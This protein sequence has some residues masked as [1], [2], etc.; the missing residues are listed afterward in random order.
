M[1]FCITSIPILFATVL[2]LG[3]LDT[4]MASASPDNF[5]LNFDKD[6]RRSIL[7]R[8]NREIH[9][10]GEKVEAKEAVND[11]LDEELQQG[12]FL[13]PLERYVKAVLASTRHLLNEQYH[14]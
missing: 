11:V 8:K 12:L 3:I 14:R 10:N 1:T 13:H 7:E 9:R 5:F 2:F 6:I 4:S